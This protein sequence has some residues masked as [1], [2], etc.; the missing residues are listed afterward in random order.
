MRDVVNIMKHIK[1]IAIATLALPLSIALPLLF[2]RHWEYATFVQNHQWFVVT[3]VPMLIGA[4]L[5]ISSMTTK[6]FRAYLL[7]TGAA[8]LI[9]PP[10]F[11]LLVAAGLF[12][13]VG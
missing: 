4:L 8:C 5:V 10:I 9:G 11:L 7:A 12:F 13:S 2:A 6:R 3:G 1:P